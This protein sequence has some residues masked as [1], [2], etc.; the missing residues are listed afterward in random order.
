MLVVSKNI[1]LAL[2]RLNFE[3]FS[4]CFR[5][6]A[7]KYREMYGFT[8]S[9]VILTYRKNRI[10]GFTVSG[11]YPTESMKPTSWGPPPANGEVESYML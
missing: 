5:D 3:D 6:F 2:V 1:M 11:V 10:Y 4:A 7:Q 9:G 8:V